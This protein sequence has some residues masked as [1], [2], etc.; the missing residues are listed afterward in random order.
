M[1]VVAMSYLMSC[2]FFFSSRRRHTRCAL[3]T[4]VQTC[5]LPISGRD[6]VHFRY[7]G[8]YGSWWVA[9]CRASGLPRV[10]SPLPPP[11][12]YPGYC[13][14]SSRQLSQ[15]S[16]PSHALSGSPT[17][18]PLISIAAFCITSACYSHATPRQA[19]LSVFLAPLH[20]VNPSLTTPPTPSP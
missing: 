11:P 18:P 15:S 10:S 13:S 17:R 3:V 8:Y 12:N 14:T 1:F 16:S 6:Q 5:A 4:G 20:P 7:R 9:L 2:F 19:L